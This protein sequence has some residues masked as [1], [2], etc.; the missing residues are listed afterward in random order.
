MTVPKELQDKAREII[1]VV[2]DAKFK[3]KNSFPKIRMKTDVD[4]WGEEYL[5]VVVI[6][7]GAHDDLNT[8]LLMDAYHE[9]LPILGDAGIHRW[10]C[11]SYRPKEE[12]DALIEELQRTNRMWALE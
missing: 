3:G 6:Y 11:I 9:M 10:P 1:K 8:R 7:T 4:E 2:L 5:Y 12:D